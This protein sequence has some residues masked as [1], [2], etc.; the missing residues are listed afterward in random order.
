MASINL[1]WNAVSPAPVSGYRIKYWPTASPSQVSTVSPNPTTNAYTITS[2]G[3]GVSYSGTIESTCTGG[4]YSTPINWSVVAPTVTY[5]YYR[6]TRYDCSNCAAG[7][8]ELEY[9]VKSTT[10][11]TLTKYYKYGAYAYR[12]EGTTQSTSNTVAD[13]S[14][15]SPTNSCSIACAVSGNYYKYPA[16]RCKDCN[17]NPLNGYVDPYT[18]I[19]CDQ[20]LSAAF[21]GRV[22]YVNGLYL[23]A[24]ISGPYELT[25]DPYNLIHNTDGFYNSCES[26]QGCSNKLLDGGLGN[27][28]GGLQ[29][30]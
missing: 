21:D 18:Y 13:L 2:I 1:T 14:E 24:H 4:T 15:V 8:S 6:T 22:V 10:E 23:I 3:A 12:I 5:Y 20:Q 7:G 17:G 30:L 26:A 28:P 16:G 19:T 27:G 9:L 25:S 11:L 29:Y